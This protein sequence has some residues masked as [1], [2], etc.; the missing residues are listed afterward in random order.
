MLLAVDDTL[1]RKRGGG[2]KLTA[3]SAHQSWGGSG[4]TFIGEM[5]AA[6]AIAEDQKAVFLF[7][8]EA[9]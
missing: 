2:P 6:K 4:K 9:S 1:A 8:Y 5:A 7:P 3:R